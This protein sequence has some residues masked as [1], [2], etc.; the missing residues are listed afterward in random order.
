MK[1]IYYP[2]MMLCCAAGL[3]NAAEQPLSHTS[4]SMKFPIARRIPLLSIIDLMS[5]EQKIIEQQK[6][7]QQKIRELQEIQQ[8]IM[9]EIKGLRM[10][11]QRIMEQQKIEQQKANQINN[12]KSGSSVVEP[13]KMSKTLKHSKDHNRHGRMRPRAQENGGSKKKS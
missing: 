4:G 9:Q 8:Q 7:E 11:Q 5:R 12:S 2:L 3:S 13:K 10:I 6:I 1:H